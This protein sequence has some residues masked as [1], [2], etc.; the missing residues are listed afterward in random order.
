MIKT[1]LTY[2]RK[3]ITCVDFIQTIIEL[4][5]EPLNLSLSFISLP[6][7]LPWFFLSR[8]IIIQWWKFLCFHLLQSWFIILSLICNSLGLESFFTSRRQVW[9]YLFL[10]ENCMN[11]IIWSNKGLTCILHTGTRYKSTESQYSLDKEIKGFYWRSQ[12]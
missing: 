11:L 7:H 1:L 2:W 4:I 6:D 12:K 10:E 3:L 9:N 5:W 8:I